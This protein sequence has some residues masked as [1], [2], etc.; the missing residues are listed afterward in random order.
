M[1]WKRVLSAIIFGFLVILIILKGGLWG[2]FILVNLVTIL[3]AV[4]FSKLANSAN[5]SVSSFSVA[6]FACL[7]CISSFRPDWVNLDLIIF[8]AIG[9]HFL[10]EI[11]RREPSSAFL[12][13]SSAFLG[14]FYIGWLLGRHL[15]LLRQIPGFDGRHIILLMAAITWSGDISAYLIGKRFGRHKVIPAISPGKS[16]EGYIAGITFSCLAAL[17]VRYWLLKDIKILHVIIMG[18]TLTIIGQIGDLAE[19]LLKRC[20]NVKDSGGLM[21]GHGGLLDR[22]DSMIF[23]A[24]AMYYY[25]KFAIL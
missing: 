22:C 4:E 18:V 15:I 7:I 12:N 14:V 16:V 25:I 23:I 24:P 17:A 1:F 5:A 6:I 3:T 13:V 2:F 21:P 8:L 20:A 10:I 19:S 11:I 9:L